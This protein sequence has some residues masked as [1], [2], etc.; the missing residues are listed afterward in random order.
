MLTFY[1]SRYYNL[2]Y[3]YAYCLN[4]SF[5]IKHTLIAMQSNNS[6]ILTSQLTGRRQQVMINLI[7]YNSNKDINTNTITSYYFLKYELN[8]YYLVNHKCMQG[9]VLY[10]YEVPSTYAWYSPGDG[11]IHCN[12]PS[13]HGGDFSLPSRQ[14]SMISDCRQIKSL[15]KRQQV[16]EKIK[17]FDRKFGLVST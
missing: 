8:L 13:Y 2:S 6:N 17:L 11:Y 3:L 4:Y 1:L 7:N 10:C 9:S 14:V 15:F 16:Q 5:I 12:P